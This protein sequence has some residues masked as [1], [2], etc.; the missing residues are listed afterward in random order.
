[1]KPL[2]KEKILDVINTGKSKTGRPITTNIDQI[3]EA[4]YFVTDS[5][6]QYRYVQQHYGMSK[7]TFYRYPKIITDNH[8]LENIYNQIVDPL[9]LYDV[10]I[11]RGRP[12]V[13]PFYPNT[14]TKKGIMMDIP[15]Y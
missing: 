10:L 2:I 5:G 8:V 7:S 15:N 9:P 3:I 1:M 13:N 4:I 12:P 11:T 6:S 14:N